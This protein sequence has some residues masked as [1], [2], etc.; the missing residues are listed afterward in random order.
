MQLYFDGS[1]AALAGLALL[2]P[3]LVV[4]YTEMHHRRLG[5]LFVV[6]LLLEGLFA[7]YPTFVI[8]LGAALAVAL[9]LLAFE[10]FF[11]TRR[12]G[13]P[14][15][16]WFSVSV[17]G[18]AGLAVLMNI[19]A[20]SRDYSYW[21]SLLHGGFV[22]SNFPRMHFAAVSVFGWVLQTRGVYSFAFNN[23]G[24]FGDFWPA[25][26]VPVV[27]ALFAIP[28]LRR[29]RVAWLVLAIVPVAGGI[30]SYQVIHN[31]CGYC[32]DR[33]L[34]P[35]TPAV[36]YLVALGIGL[37]LA[38]AKRIFRW[39]AVGASGVLA[40]FAGLSAWRSFDQFSTQS[41]FLTTSLRSVLGAVPDKGAT[42]LLEG[43]GEGPK[44][45]A[46]EAFVYEMANEQTAGHLSIA[47]DVDDREGLAYL[48]TSPLEPPIFKSNYQY[49]LTRVPGI[50]T[51]RTIIASAPGIAL[52]R[53]TSGLDVSLDYGAAVSLMPSG[54]PDG[55]AWVIGPL[56]LVVADGDKPPDRV[57]ASFILPT[58]STVVPPQ[59][60]ITFTRTGIQLE[61][62]IPT[63]A[64]GTVRV[65]DITLP[66]VAMRL[67][68][69]TASYGT[70]R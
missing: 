15:A 20:F 40:I 38:N 53:R 18:V 39:I 7:L 32:E 4:A 8:T 11:K 49:I 14:E 46:E 31:A 42:V 52:E 35:V 59:K 61:A 51:R 33:S 67:V 16:I 68:A 21:K 10:H 9:G 30:G 50:T 1:E 27:I 3:L 26:L 2:V 64:S 43:F 12:A 37:L 41:Y 19:F 45:P 34:L 36:V 55:S 29:F 56:Q 70:C 13:L 28:A 63:A 66:I 22:E 69:M 17:L 23:Q 5:G 6:A 47:A 62:C 44:A 65:A 58:V 57:T 54:D 24:A 25:V 60:G 48:G